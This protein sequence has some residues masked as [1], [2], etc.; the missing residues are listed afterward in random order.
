M[1]RPVPPACRQ[2]RLGCPELVA[3]SSPP[4][5]SRLLPASPAS[6]PLCSHRTMGVP[7]SS[8]VTCGMQPGRWEALCAVAGASLTDLTTVH[9]QPAGGPRSRWRV[10]CTSGALTC[11]RLPVEQAA[12][13]SGQPSALHQFPVSAPNRVPFLPLHG[14]AQQ[15]H[16]RPRCR[17]ALHLP[18]GR[19]PS[20]GHRPACGCRQQAHGR[21]ARWAGATWQDSPPTR[22]PLPGAAR[23]RS[24]QLRRHC[25]SALLHALCGQSAPRRA[26]LPHSRQRPPAACTHHRAAPAR[27]QHRPPPPCCTAARWLSLHRSSRTALCLCLAQCRCQQRR[28]HEPHAPP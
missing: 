17:S 15:H 18:A 25:P 2:L 28:R 4:G 27:C 3:H 5:N 10:G 22:L 8:T 19:P 14:P 16:A 9:K 20:C 26:Q 24:G 11:S 12:Q 13:W 23:I 7:G 21:R 1:L 6:G